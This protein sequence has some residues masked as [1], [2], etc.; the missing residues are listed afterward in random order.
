MTIQ[1]NTLDDGKAQL[2]ITGEMTIYCAAEHHQ[3]MLSISQNQTH[4]TLE[5][6]LSGVE[7]V[8]SSGIQNLLALK[9]A[10]LSQDKAFNITELSPPVEDALTIYNLFSEL[11]LEASQE[12][13]DNTS[14]VSGA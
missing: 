12:A 7:E 9:N 5:I 3:E 2:C 10:M 13:P 8:D 1:V 11:G 4:Q 6:D 14:P